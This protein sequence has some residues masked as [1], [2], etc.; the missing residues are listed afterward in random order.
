MAEPTYKLRMQGLRKTYGPVVALAGADVAVGEGEFLTLL[1]PSGS[2]KTTMLLL[3]AGLMQPDRGELWI[4]G[5]LAT[6]MPPHKRDIGMVFQNYALFPH[7]TVY[8]NIAFPLRMRR[9]PAAKIREEVHRVL[10]IVQLSGVEERLPRQLSG[11]QQQ[12]IALARCMA[13]RPPII[14]MDEPLGALDKKLREQLQLEIRHLHQTLDITVLYVTHDQEEALVMSDRICLMNEGE[15]EQL[16]TPDDLYFR[17]ETVFAAD[18]LGESNL[19]DAMVAGTRGRAVQ[20]HGPNHVTI[21]APAR[22][23]VFQ[24]QNVKCMVRPENVRVL[25]PGEEADNTLVA[26]LQDVILLGQVTKYYAKPPDGT[27]VC[28][29][30]LTRHSIPKFRPGEEVRFGF[31]LES[32]VVLPLD[33]R[34]AL[35]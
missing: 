19:L 13:Y 14:L 29:T 34:T 2:G 21:K 33:K 30:Q 35:P 16:G 4:D 26:H 5:K 12:R 1:G 20:L 22:G 28:A 23:E 7:M 11:G 3:I 25:A 32:T 27:D 6:Y 17:P 8:E 10:D 15:I 24:G 9:V 31:D 18:F